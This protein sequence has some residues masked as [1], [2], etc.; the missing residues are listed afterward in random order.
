MQFLTDISPV[1]GIDGKHL[2]AFLILACL[3]ATEH[4]MIQASLFDV[5]PI[6]LHPFG[7]QMARVVA[8]LSAAFILL[9]ITNREWLVAIFC[10][11]FVLSLVVL[12]YRQYFHRPLS[13]FSAVRNFR[14]G[15]K[16]SSFA[17]QIIPP[18]VRLAMSLSLAVKII[19]AIQ[20]SSQP[21][22]NSIQ[23]GWLTVGIPFATLAGMVLLLQKTSF[24]FTS[25]RKSSIT[26]AVYVYGYTISWIAEFLM[27]PKAR[28]IAR[29]VTILQEPSPDR[30]EGTESPWPMGENVVIVQLESFGWEILNYCVNGRQVTPFLNEL[31]DSSR[32]FKLQVYHDNGSADMD[33]ALLSG[34]LPSK[35]LV[36]YFIPGIPYTNALPRFMQRHGYRTMALHGAS[37]EF[38]NR[39][40]NFV[41]MGWDEILFREEFKGSHVNQSHWGVRDQE[42][43]RF[44]SK[45]MRE[46][47]SPEF[48]FIITL[49]SHGP[50]NLISENEKTIFPGSRI[51]QE[52]YFNS[53]S[54]LDRNIREY[55]SSLPAGTFVM[56]YG[57]HTAGVNYREF[58]P[59]RKNAAE[60]VPCLVHLRSG[61]GGVQ[62]S[63]DSSEDL[64]A[65]LSIHD[66]INF[67]RRQIARS[68]GSRHWCPGPGEEEG[69]RAQ[70]NDHSSAGPTP[71]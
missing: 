29:E 70:G 49:D 46:A 50:F 63:P 30:L 38:F 60:Y 48:H 53:M 13:L 40:A 17:I 33:Y 15:I 1:G 68:K 61:P 23:A 19:L 64:P 65:D 59:A 57:D 71:P 25:I 11:D 39:R 27:A 28:E 44:S 43:F 54:A 47:T 22:V 8:N 6:T 7:Y 35:H 21:F 41:R 32:V 12:A 20:L 5:P 26:R 4:F 51:W 3:W 55:V 9:L 34:G 69:H 56:L 66:I 58:A 52:N 14:E 10:L 45:R 67:M 16:V 24:R 62:L 37:G 36:S 31:A 2:I 18:G 42:I